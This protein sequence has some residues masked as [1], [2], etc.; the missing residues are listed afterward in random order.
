MGLF[1]WWVNLLF[2]YSLQK[3]KIVI[4]GSFFSNVFKIDYF[5]RGPR[6]VSGSKIGFGLL[7][8]A[9]CSLHNTLTFECFL[10]VDF[11]Y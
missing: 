10:Q 3:G 1:F 8:K 4:C 5:P 11:S 6:E 9:N 2:L 7:L